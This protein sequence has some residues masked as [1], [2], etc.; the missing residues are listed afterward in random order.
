[1]EDITYGFNEGGVK[2]YTY[3]EIVD[4]IDRVFLPKSQIDYTKVKSESLVEKFKQEASRIGFTYIDN[5]VIFMIESFC[6][7]VYVDPTYREKEHNDQLNNRS[8]F[9]IQNQ[10]SFLKSCLIENFVPCLP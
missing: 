1:M 4:L 5:Y 3:F 8:P 9:Y 2:N 7:D 10:L 6:K